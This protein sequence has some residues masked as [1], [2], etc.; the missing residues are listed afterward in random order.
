[1]PRP[2]TQS[3]RH[4]ALLATSLLICLSFSITVMASDPVVE[5]RVP[6]LDFEGVVILDSITMLDGGVAQGSAMLGKT[7][8]TF[9]LDTERAHLWKGGR[10]LVQA[11]GTFGDEP[12]S[13]AGDVQVFD[14]IE[15][16][17]DLGILEAWIEQ[18]LGSRSSILV[19][20]HD[21]NREFDVI[22]SAGELLNSSFGIGPEISQVG[23]S[24]FPKT[25]P[26][27]RLEF[28]P[29]SRSY[30]KVAGYSG[31]ECDE[32]AGNFYAMESG[33]LRDGI[34]PFEDVKVAVGAWSLN[35]DEAQSV[36]DS[37]ASGGYLIAEATY[38]T[39]GGRTIGVF[40]RAGRSSSD[41]QPIAGYTGA[42]VRLG[43][44]FANRPNDVVS[45]GV[46]RAAIDE[47]GRLAGASGTETTV[48]LTWVAQL[49][50]WIAIQPDV[51]YIDSPA[52]AIGVHHAL[53]G[54][55][56]LI[57]TY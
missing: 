16:G 17:E 43:N 22:E 54:G 2:L 27:A 5:G 51:Q 45:L 18:S 1:M 12:S 52:G 3:I 19:G 29:T 38:V 55:I 50:D 20:Y 56:R 11:L 9:D 57:L 26:G 35:L 24:L 15:A 8:F 49:N 30:L 53:V 28:R 39:D 46:A 10:V 25:H 33:W 48:E 37:I 21:L 47:E 40:G 13:M 32:G 44:F 7:A 36:T 14:N 34:G 31:L 6:G 23:P 42:G 4:A 41:C